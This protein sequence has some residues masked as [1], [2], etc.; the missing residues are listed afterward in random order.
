MRV[1]TYTLRIMSDTPILMTG[2]EQEAFQRGM[3]HALDAIN[4][5][6]PEGFYCKIDES[7]EGVNLAAVSALEIMSRELGEMADDQGR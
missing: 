2:V 5:A 4:D 3:T 7:G 1:A 6:L